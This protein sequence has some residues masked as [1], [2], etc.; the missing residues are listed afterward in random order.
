M[1]D[2]GSSSAGFDLVGREREVEQL[3]RF[4]AALATGP[5]ALVIRGDPG[6]GKTTLWRHAVVG[7]RSAGFHVAVARPAA[8]EMA[9]D[10][11]GI[12][13]LFE[14]VGFDPT[15]LR[16]EDDP[17]ARGRVVLEWLRELA[18]SAPSIVA[19]DDVQWLDAVSAR[20]LRYALRRIEDEPVGVVSTVRSRSRPGCRPTGT[21]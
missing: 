19:I 3:E 4:A 16:D 18:M 9:L 20:A 1:S 17:F 21:S 6:I 10:L 13:D 12:V 15:G 14:S 2:A 11:E 5:R 7:S 8:E